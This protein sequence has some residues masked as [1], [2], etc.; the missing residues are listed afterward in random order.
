MWGLHLVLDVR[1]GRVDAV[2]SREAILAWCA[3]LVQRIG[4]R[5]YGDPILAHFAAHDPEAAG[6]SLVQLI[7]TSAIT[8]H[9][10]D[11]NGD[12]YLD[13]FSCKPFD[14]QAAIDCVVEH[15]QPQHIRSQQI[16]R[17]A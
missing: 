15:F 10:V 1:G 11:K 13:V 16:E 6:Y 17:Q 7:E 14:P 8:G 2:R 12:M 5:A 4:M 3:D 9:F